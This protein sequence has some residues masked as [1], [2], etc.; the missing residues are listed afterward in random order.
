MGRRSGNR[1]RGE[2]V[3]LSLPTPPTLLSAG[4]D[5]LG[6]AAAA[7][8]ASLFKALGDPVRVRLLTLVRQA[9]NGETCFCDLADEF[10]MPQS[11]LSHH[12][13]ILVRAGVLS[14]ERR[15]T[16]SWYRVEPGP[17]A[18]MES[19]LRPGGPFRDRSAVDRCE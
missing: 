1:E 12:L 16:W 7:A 17:L 8:A 11:S 5:T 3:P 2:V 13:K 14:R 15:G 19:L 9:S 18:A 10:D 4:H 6:P